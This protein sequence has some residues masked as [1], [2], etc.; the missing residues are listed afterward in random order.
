MAA[1]DFALGPTK[2]PLI[3]LRI[4]ASGLSAS[5]HL[6]GGR[7]PKAGQ[8]HVIVKRHVLPHGARVALPAAAA[9]ELPVDAVRV[10]QLC[11][12]YL[13]ATGIGHARSKTYVVSSS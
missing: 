11:A 2:E 10:I 6:V 13:Q 7:G 8:D 9:H 3:G 5:R 4:G 12:N 1:L